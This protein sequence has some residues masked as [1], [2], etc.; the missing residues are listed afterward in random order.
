[1]SFSAFAVIVVLVLCYFGS[2]GLRVKPPEGR[3]NL[4]MDL[5]ET[6]SL[7][8][9]SNVL[10]RGVPVGK[11]S[12]TSTNVGVATVDFWID[13]RYHVPLDS[14]VRIE[15]LSALG[16]SYIALMPRSEGG[17]MLQDG[18]RIATEV[19]AQP[20]SISE[21]AT[22]VVRVLDQL[23]PGAVERVIHQLDAA[24]PNPTT[25]LPNVSRTSIL[26][27]NAATDMRGRGRVLLDNFQ[28]LLQNAEWVGPV[29]DGLTP[30]LVETFKW[31]QDMFKGIPAF[32]HRGEPENIT[33]FN[34]LIARV[35]NFLDIA[36]GDLKVLGEAM[37][38]KLNAIAATLMNFDTGQILDSLL[39]AVPSDGRITLRLAPA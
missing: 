12:N 36:G 22:S 35:Q 18:Q 14:E 30:S 13:R 9:G 15:N 21:L 32:L 28:T 24:L 8:T 16:E 39:A 31:S 34:N 1:M 37:L 33:N 10:L 27:R 26:L 38:P 20:P 4:S 25:V 5:S 11:V 17:P 6:N 23:D 3:T 19:I 2:L 29:L 7:V